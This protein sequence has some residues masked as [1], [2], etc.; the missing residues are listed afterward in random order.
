MIK[1]EKVKIGKNLEMDSSLF[2]LEASKN[3]F[4]SV[5]E[6][7]SS[8]IENGNDPNASSYISIVSIIATL[9]ITIVCISG[10]KLDAEKSRTIICDLAN[11]V[12][13]FIEERI[14]GKS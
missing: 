4:N 8:L 11:V 9:G 10:N 7:R 14:E 6:M 12:V 3:M 1:P 5:S 2:I 13:N